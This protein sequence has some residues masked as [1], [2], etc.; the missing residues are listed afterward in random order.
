MGVALQEGQRLLYS[1]QAALAI[2]AALQV[3]I[4]D[5]VMYLL[6]TCSCSSVIDTFAVGSA[7]P[8]RTG[9]CGGGC[10]R[11]SGR[12]SSCLPNTF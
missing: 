4:M 1:G 12:H 9:I 2:P 8:D 10:V 7:I 11:G 3:Y 5:E 6:Y